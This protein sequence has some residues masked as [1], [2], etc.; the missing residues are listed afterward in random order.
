MT[1]TDTASIGEG[2]TLRFGAGIAVS[3]MVRSLRFVAPDNDNGMFIIR[4]GANG[5]E[6]RI[7]GFDPQNPETGT[8]GIEYFEF[9]DG[10]LLS[11]RELV[12]NTFVVQG[13][14]AD[15]SLSG[16]AVGDRLYGY[17][18]N[19]YLD[20]YEGDD[21]LTGGTGDDVMVGGAGNDVYIVDLG[22]GNDTVI[23]ST[24]AA[25]EN[26]LVFG[27]GIARDSLR[28]EQEVDGLRIRYSN[29]DSILLSGYASADG[30][31][32]VRAVRHPGLQPVG[33]SRRQFRGSA[34]GPAAVRSGVERPDPGPA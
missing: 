11:F 23:D 15:D 2:N 12:R 4:L 8:H 14:A 28:F 6:V 26:L 22:D 3:D 31:R 18:G 32:V 7:T 19:D 1:I 17:E 21:A 25:A 10:S 30:E 33:S 5:D 27:E 34:P 29:E 24:Q 16:T 20:S 13:D 9:A